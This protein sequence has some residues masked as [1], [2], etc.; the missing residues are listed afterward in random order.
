[1]GSIIKV[2]EY[3]DFG[4]NAIM[5]SD[6]AGVVTPNATGIKNTPAF[7]AYLSSNQAVSD[8]TLT[9]VQFDTEVFDTDGAYDNSTYKYTPQTSGKYFFYTTVSGF[10][11]ASA[12]LNVFTIKFYKNGSSYKQLYNDNSG[13]PLYN[14]NNFSG[15]VIDMNGSTDY[16]EVYGLID[17]I[18]AGS[19]AFQSS[20]KQTLF[21]A[22]K[23]IG[24]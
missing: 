16:V 1:M 8:N 11:N 15:T 23:L 5:T 6:G 20:E 2:N 18:S 12:D 3:K 14:A 24:A 10:G 17:G 7:E 9:K 22:Y 13:N 4:N 21:G 19:E